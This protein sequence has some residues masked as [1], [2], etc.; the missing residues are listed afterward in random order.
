MNPRRICILTDGHLDTFT[1]KTALGLLR[2]CPDEVVAVLDRRNVGES[3]VDLVGTG[4]DIPIIDSI[5]AAQ[6]LS[7]NQLLMGVALPGGQLPEAWREFLEQG[8]QSGMDIVSGMHARLNSDERFSQLAREHG[9]TLFD[10]RNPGPPPPVG[11]GK[12]A[13]T[14][15]KR[16]LTVGSDCNVG[17]RVTAL[18]ITRELKQRDV[19]VEF[20]ATGQTGIMISG[21]G[22]PADAVIS[23]FLTGYIE[24]GVLERGD[25]DYV[26]VE[27]QGSL[28][29]PAFSPVTLGLI[30]GAM[31]DAMILC[32]HP[33]R[34]NMRATEYPVAGLK[35]LIALHEAIMKPLSPSK[36]IAVALN[37]FGMASAEAD[38][39]VRAIA[40][41]TGLPAVDPIKMGPGALADAVMS[42]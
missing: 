18:E 32:H 40:E 41:L 11:S 28:L 24:R 36:V 8:L 1:A 37:C 35:E 12:A 19:N 33:P 31:P 20:L 26:L 5:D 4:K 17:K 7:A 27:G 2:Y 38:D 6:K 14:R 3:L 21:S 42:V 16:I 30:H 39:A 9:R 29:N 13:S 22:V 15:A 25:A 34:K 10:V 23:D